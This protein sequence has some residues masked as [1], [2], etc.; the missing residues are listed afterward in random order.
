M[1]KIKPK[2]PQQWKLF[3]WRLDWCAQSCISFQTVARRLC[4]FCCSHLL[5]S[6]DY[7]MF[8]WQ[9]DVEIFI[10]VSLFYT[11]RINF[12]RPFILNIC[13]SRYL[14]KAGIKWDIE[15]LI[16]IIYCLLLL[17]CTVNRFHADLT[18]NKADCIIC[19][20]ENLG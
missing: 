7:Q 1:S 9:H 2:M 6:R 11:K 16:G 17:V 13:K 19:V 3:S 8:L 4:L 10:S 5:K 14:D 12:N 15:P 18:R 20:I